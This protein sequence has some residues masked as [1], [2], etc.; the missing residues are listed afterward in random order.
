MRILFALILILTM[1]A[2][3]EIPAGAVW[4]IRSTATAANINGALFDTGAS[5]ALTDGS[6]TSA[7][8]N[9]PVLSSGLYTFVA[10]DVGH[11]VYIV[12]NTGANVTRG[13]YQIAS[14]NAGAATLSA[15][16]GQGVWHNPTNRTYTISTSAG[17]SSTASPTSITFGIDYSQSNA[18]L[19]AITDLVIDGTTNTNVTSAGCPFGRNHV[20]NGLKVA[21]GTGFTVDWF[22][23]QSISGSV[24]T[25]DKSAGTLSSTGGVAKLGGAASLGSASGATDD[26]LFEKGIAG[27]DFFV[28]NGSYTIGGTV[29]IAATGGTQ[30][31][32]RIIGYNSLRG[33]AP[34]GSTRPTLNA[35]ANTFTLATNWDYYSVI[36]TGSAASVLT[37]AGNGKG[38][39]SKGINTSTTAARVAITSAAD[40]FL[41]GI[42]AIS[43]RGR[44]ISVSGSNATITGCY[45]H[46]SD[47]GILN[48]T[49]TNTMTISN[50]I[51]AHN[52]TTGIWISAANTA[53]ITIDHVTLYGAESNIGTG[54]LIATGAT[55]VRITNSII[56]GFAT[57]VSHADA[58]SVG[59]DAYNFFHGNTT[60]VTNWALGVGSVT[61]TNPSFTSITQITGTGA[62]SSTNVLTAGSGT[63][64]GSVVDNVD[65]V[66]LTSGSG[67][68]FA[69]GK[70]LI[71]GHTTTTLTLS[72]NITTSGSGSAIAWEVTSGH[73]FAIGTALKS[74]GYPGVFPGGLTT[75][76]M[77]PGAVPRQEPAGGGGTR[78]Y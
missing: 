5:F 48:S 45:V 40:A 56:K 39:F 16:I 51:V 44:A 10:G 49:T 27:N 25:L 18:A 24:A 31:P 17:I 59:Y 12:S 43:Y 38:F 32:I 30:N 35:K 13:W 46:D 72:S 74:L 29:T 52:A 60:D 37:M 6:A 57:G 77:D 9:S 34:T 33:D 73:N 11:W 21:S 78:I 47:V 66:T 50:C 7:T 15:A 69:A 41:F 76:Y 68:G 63:P 58:Q 1:P 70:Y 23:I 67:T 3:A 22:V 61:G 53:N 28:E 42:E 20:G 26:A 4:T 55:D 64:F 65:F 62:S 14:V 36:W 19:C 54:V 2:W 8:G 75:G 71:T